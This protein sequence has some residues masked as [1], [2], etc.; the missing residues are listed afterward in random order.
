MNMKK[1]QAIIHAV[2]LALLF[3]LPMAAVELAKKTDT[4]IKGLF[5]GG[6]LKFGI[7][8]SPK[9]DRFADKW[10]V[11]IGFDKRLVIPY[12]TW[13][14]EFQPFYRSIDDPDFSVRSVVC[15]LFFNL[16]GGYPVGR[17]V[18]SDMLR[19]LRPFKVYGGLG[20]GSEL[21]LSYIT[22]R[23]DDNTEFKTRFAWHMVFGIEYAL[24]GFGV[25]IEFQPLW[26]THSELDPS[27]VS[28]SCI[29]FGIR[30]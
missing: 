12:L 18:R 29:L 21:S 13:G 19:F 22:F 2:L 4:D 6:F 27:A 7:Q 1:N 10:L 26:V 24:K 17:L 8:T 9:M 16:K 14:L 3:S 28:S 15:N 23:D 11:S 30:F 25:F 20:A 5:G